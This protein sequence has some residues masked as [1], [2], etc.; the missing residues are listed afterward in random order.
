MV[1]LACL[2]LSLGKFT[3][4]FAVVIEGCVRVCGRGNIMLNTWL[5]EDKCSRLCCLH[6]GALTLFSPGLSEP[7]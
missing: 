5:Y 7:S 4:T 3:E 1:T 2:F 6:R